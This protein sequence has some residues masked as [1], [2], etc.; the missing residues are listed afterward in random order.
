MGN[1]K[2][3]SRALRG[4]AHVV[5]DSE[6]RMQDFGK[7]HVPD[8]EWKINDF[9]SLLETG[10]KSAASAAFHCSGYNWYLK[11]N[12]V[13]K[14]TG[15]E[16]PYVALSLMTS[17]ASMMPGHT[18]HVVFELSIYNHSKGMY[19]GCKAT[20]NFHFKNTYSKEHCLI[21]L[22]ELL[23]SPAFLVNDSCV[24]GV[25]ILKIDVSSPEKKAF[26]VQKKAT[27][28]Q[29]LFVQKKGFVKGTYTWNIDNFL[30]LDLDHFV[31]SPTFEVG[32]HKWYPIIFEVTLPI[33]F[34]RYVQMYPRGDK[35]ST[36]CL[37]LYLRLD[38]SDE[39]HL[40]SKK[41]IV[42]TLSILDQKNGKHLT[43]T[44]GLLVFTGGHGWGWAD[45]LGLKKLKDPSGGYVVG[46]SCIMKA[47]LTIFGSS[48][49]G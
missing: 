45:F 13:R 37:S 38:A 17:R 49:D 46:S 19:C 5:P 18:V 23:K 43:A 14:E 8:L 29:N 12:P 27:T 25:E 42:M 15:S 41:V 10:A 31:C 47:D 20:Y 7:T 39:L 34:N 11:V 33:F 4:K 9:S 48:I 3:S 1:C 30:E 16:T 21:P 35:H 44:S 32:G 22:Q 24:F 26:V 2:S 6:W 28:V 36:D 40:E